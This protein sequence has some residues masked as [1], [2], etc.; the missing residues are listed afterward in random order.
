MSLAKRVQKINLE[1]I[2]EIDP[3][4]TNVSEDM[5]EMDIADDVGEI[6]NIHNDIEATT[7]ITEELN[8]LNSDV[9]EKIAQVDNIDPEQ[10]DPVDIAVVNESINY[11]CK[12]LG[13]TR[14]TTIA[15]E[16]IRS[17]APHTVESLK[18]ELEGIKDTIV[19]YSKKAWEKIL[20]FLRMLGAKLK[21]LWNKIK[22][23]VRPTK[24]KLQTQKQVLQLKLDIINEAV[25]E[26]TNEQPTPMVVLNSDLKSY[27]K[28]LVASKTED[29]KANKQEVKEALKEEIKALPDLRITPKDNKDYIYATIG[30]ENCVII[31]ETVIKKI[32]PEMFKAFDTLNLDN[33]TE[34]EEFGSKLS[35]I[36]A[37]HFKNLK[38]DNKDALNK[39]YNGKPSDV[40]GY[41]PRQ[42]IGYDL[43][44]TYTYP[45]GEQRSR[46]YNNTGLQDKTTPQF[47]K[48]MFNIS[49]L[50][51][52]FDRASSLAMS[53]EKD[54][55]IYASKYEKFL[56]KAYDIGDKLREKRR[57]L[58]DDSTAGQAYVE[59]THK[60]ERLNSITQ[61]YLIKTYV[62][63]F[64]ECFE[65][66]QT[67]NTNLIRLVGS[68]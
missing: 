50:E 66:L 65:Y 18:V 10:P 56:D 7:D 19:D 11:Y 23:F 5:L 59:I 31:Y 64:L 1:S 12:A 38:T 58:K 39:T 45:N 35:D 24:Q 22:E 54:Y 4:E 17:S 63:T 13:V 49:Y 48:N 40:L 41:I 27:Y 42:Y 60:I 57:A 68:L 34:L 6:A 20:E 61:G 26:T 32:L 44:V 16:D 52:V 14:S 46:I 2:E 3:T 62:A 47:D 29:L 67:F 25:K 33:L 9:E 37:K 51:K 43:V 36:I 53:A 8:D 30:Y 15:L 21:E 28:Q 55:S